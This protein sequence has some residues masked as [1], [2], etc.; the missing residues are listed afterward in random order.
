M[1]NKTVRE[2]VSFAPKLPPLC[3]R[4]T[5]LES[6]DV[7]GTFEKLQLDLKDNANRQP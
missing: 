2:A 6:D 7:N 4:R 5:I 1:H 3:F